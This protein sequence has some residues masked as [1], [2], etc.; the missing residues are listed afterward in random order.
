[1]ARSRA[2]VHTSIWSPDGDFRHLS[3]A[4]QRA[5]FMVLSQSDLS[6]CG[7][8]A[9][10]IPRWARMAKD[11]TAGA[12]RRAISELVNARYMVTDE[13]TEELWIRTFAK[14]DGV[15]KQP[16]VVVA[17]SKDFESIQSEPIREGFLEGLP[18]ELVEGLPEGYRERLGRPFAEGVLRVR[19]RPP[20]PSPT[21]TPSTDSDPKFKTLVRSSNSDARGASVA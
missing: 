17:M 12:L 10:T 4:A 2:T 19:A 9:L 21:P 11:T 18:E 5:Y 6:L 3:G 1:M 16:N 20:S 8:I 13:E 14:H 15:L 7:V